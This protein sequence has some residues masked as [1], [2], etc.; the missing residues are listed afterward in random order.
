MGLK[1]ILVYYWSNQGVCAH[2]SALF[3]GDF[4]PQRENS[5]VI[6]DH[7]FH[8]TGL[9][10][11]N[12]THPGYSKSILKRFLSPYMMFIQHKNVKYLTV[13]Y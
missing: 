10:L 1:I 8:L 4:Q 5:N 7:I 13:N 12:H 9:L 11:G 3:S 2:N 6:S